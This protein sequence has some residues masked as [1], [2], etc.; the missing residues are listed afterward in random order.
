MVIIQLVYLKK[1]AQEIGNKVNPK[2][3]PGTNDNLPFLLKEQP[4]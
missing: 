1:A 2:K 4:Q 3:A